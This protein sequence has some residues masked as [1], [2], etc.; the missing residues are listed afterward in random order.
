MNIQFLKRNRPAVLLSDKFRSV[1]FALRNLKNTIDDYEE[2]DKR[3]IPLIGTVSAIANASDS[4]LSNVEEKLHHRFSSDASKHLG[5]AAA[6]S[7][8]LYTGNTHDIA[9]DQTGLQFAGDQYFTA[10]RIGLAY[11]ID[12]ILMHQSRFLQTWQDFRLRLADASHAQFV[13]SLPELCAC[14][15]DLLRRN[16]VVVF[17]ARHEFAGQT[18]RADTET[19]DAAVVEV[20]TNVL[21]PATVALVTS[22]ASYCDAQGIK[23]ES[24]AIYDN[25][26]SLIS[27]RYQTV[28]SIFNSAEFQRE[29]EA[30]LAD[31][32]PRLA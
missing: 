2:H 28:A 11:G 14:Y 27:A 24:D 7:L 31:W 32:T 23:K 21:L 5:Q 10:K 1:R 6:C 9:S 29:F 17:P 20:E 16:E 12:N 15:A 26:V 3:A 25:C 8:Q 18:T 30:F 19:S 22:V 4:A 13:E